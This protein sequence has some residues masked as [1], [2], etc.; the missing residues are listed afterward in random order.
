MI[1]IS[2]TQCSRCVDT[3]FSVAHFLKNQT[4]RSVNDVWTL[5][6][7]RVHADL[8]LCGRCV[9]A[10]RTQGERAADTYQTRTEHRLDVNQ[11]HTEP[12]SALDSGSS[13]QS[14]RAGANQRPITLEVVFRMNYR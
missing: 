5:S 1:Q 9:D 2:C 4:K 10:G 13:H 12:G 11:T 7:H 8:A 6:G 14:S 3:A